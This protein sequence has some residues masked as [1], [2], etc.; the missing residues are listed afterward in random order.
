VSC[1]SH[2]L[3]FGPQTFQL[4]WP[5]GAKYDCQPDFPR[6]HMQMQFPKIFTPK[7]VVHGNVVRKSE[8]EIFR[9]CSFKSLDS[10]P[11]SKKKI[12]KAVEKLFALP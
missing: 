7:K 3:S 9:C 5:K 2:S 1:S 12:G 11:W 6:A 8:S 10:K 4:L